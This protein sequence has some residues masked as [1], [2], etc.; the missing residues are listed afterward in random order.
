[1]QTTELS[2]LRTAACVLTAMLTLGIADNLI[3]LLAED[4]GLHQFH[5]LRSLLAVTGLLVFAWTRAMPI[6]WH[7]GWPVFW[8]GTLV[9]LAMYLYFASLAFLP[10]GTVVA[11]LF[12]APIFVLMINTLW[13]QQRLLSRHLFAVALG[14]AGMLCIT[15]TE[16]SGFSLVLVV[17]VL[18]GFF[19][20]IANVIA[21]EHCQDESVIVLSI[22]VF[23]ALGL[24]GGA[25]LLAIPTIAS[26]IP[27]TAPDFVT[28]AWRPLTLRASLLVVFHAMCASLAIGLLTFAYQ[29]GIPTRVA[30]LEYTLLVFA[31]VFAWLFWQELPT[32]RAVAGMVLIATAG[33]VITREQQRS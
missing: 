14:F 32:G 20:A 33:L 31:S 23:S 26:L 6:R 5:F 15:L 17:P 30:V 2:T 21:R 16:E 19:Y 7:R 25:A 10:I 11:G 27:T 12:T 24:L 8:R 29:R 3:R 22:A 13:F 9:G 4:I 18:A 28:D 1:M